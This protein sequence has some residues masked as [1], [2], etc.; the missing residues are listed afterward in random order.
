MCTHK[1]Q[2]LISATNVRNQP[3]KGHFGRVRFMS[4]IRPI[5]GMSHGKPVEVFYGQNRRNELK[6]TQ[7]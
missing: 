1:T 5:S 3:Q 6:L 4:G 2:V 7:R